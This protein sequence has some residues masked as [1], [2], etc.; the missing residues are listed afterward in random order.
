[1]VVPAVPRKAC[2]IFCAAE[3]GMPAF[4]AIDAT[5]DWKDW[6]SFTDSTPTAA[7]PTAPAARVT[8]PNVDMVWVNFCPLVS[9]S[10]N[11]LEMASAAEATGIPVKFWMALPSFE[12]APPALVPASER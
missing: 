5:V 11:L 9:M 2:P 6:A 7:R 10:E 4:A 1:M 3:T 12:K 8:P